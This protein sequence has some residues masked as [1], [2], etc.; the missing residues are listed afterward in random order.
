MNIT[1]CVTALLGA[2]ST[3]VM[4]YI[5]MATPIGPW[6]APTLVLC[7]LA[8]FSCTSQTPQELEQSLVYTTVAASIGGIL[9]TACGFT[10]PTL[11]FLDPVLF[12]AWL[13][14]PYYF[15]GTCSLIVFV[16]G[17]YGLWIANIT[18][19]MFI[20]ERN[21]P[22]PIGQMMYKMI[23]VQR[24]LKK[25]IELY[26][27][28]V[29]TL[30]FCVFQDGI[31]I[32]QGF[33]PKKILLCSSACYYGITVPAIQLYV[34]PMLW[35]I[36]FVT[37][38]IIIQPL[39][40]G[41]LSK[42][43]IVHPLQGIFFPDI[44]VADFILAFCS[45]MVVAGTLEA[46]MPHRICRMIK[47]RS[48]NGTSYMQ[49]IIGIDR[50]FLYEGCF[51]FLVLMSVLYYLGFTLLSQLYL[52]LFTFIAVY[53]V[54]SIAGEIG[55][56]QL[57]RFAT[58]V[59]MPALFLFNLDAVQITVLSL[60]VEASS[61]VAVDILFGRKLIQ[62]SG[63]SKER[64]IYYQY[65][66]LVVG[67]ITVGTVFWALMHYLQ[68]GSPELFAQRSQARAL[69]LTVKQFNYTI[70]IVG[71]FY[72]LLLKQVKL[73]PM[74]VL[75]GLLMPLD[76]SLGLVVGGL[77]HMI[78]RRADDWIPFWSGAFAANSMWMLVKSIMS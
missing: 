2:F 12:N 33:I 32:I 66:G 39:L 63:V 64:A 52:L 23:V 25:A 37:G 30:L 38:P 77:L 58:F 46:F 17:W 40:I 59:L 31:A 9:A 27:G 76:I 61:G 67:S 34:W 75:G 4:A 69:L 56:A 26:V 71:A 48:C 60:F 15:M 45:G 6:I 22:F 53:Q 28:F 57:G 24:K 5:S 10:L 1:V 65:F 49:Q 42:I 18:D 41:S 11:Y 55:L 19:H 13:S 29:A 44:A 78:T 16:A 47:I 50:R 21:L 3:A 72:G 20:Q 74:L 62:L 7:A 35:A 68:L 36:G 51:L 43:C 8:I 14:R 54:I 70:V 73:S